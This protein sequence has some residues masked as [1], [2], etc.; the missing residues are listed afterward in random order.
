MFVDGAFRDFCE[1]DYREEERIPPS[2]FRRQ[3]MER[4]EAH[5]RYSQSFNEYTDFAVKGNRDRTNKTMYTSLRKLDP[6]SKQT[7]AERRKPSLLI[8]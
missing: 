8:S 2:Y 3:T 5:D 1:L 4:V 7:K 6:C